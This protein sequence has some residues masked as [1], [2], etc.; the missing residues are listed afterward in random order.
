MQNWCG[1]LFVSSIAL[2]CYATP[3]IA[4]QPSMSRSAAS[5]VGHVGE[6]LTR[7]QPTSAIEAGGRLETRIQNRIPSRFQSRLDKYYNANSDDSAA[8]LMAIERALKSPSGSQRR[9]D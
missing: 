8:A 5:S 3:T 7:N 9:K 1:R 6:R 4:Q 2:V